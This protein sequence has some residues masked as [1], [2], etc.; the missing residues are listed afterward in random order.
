[1]THEIFAGCSQS[2]SQSQPVTDHQRIQTV[3]PK[4]NQS[5]L[6]PPDQKNRVEASQHAFLS[7]E[8]RRRWARGPLARRC[9]L[10]ERRSRCHQGGCSLGCLGR[11]QHAAAGGGGGRGRGRGRRRWLLLPGL[12][13]DCGLQ[14]REGCHRGCAGGRRPRRGQLRADL[15]AAGVALLGHVRQEGAEWRQRGRRHALR[16]GGGLARQHWARQGA[17]ATGA[18][19]GAVPRPIVQR[20]VGAGWQHGHRGDGRPGPA[21]PQR[22]RR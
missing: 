1:M 11:Q 18:R 7:C 22:A 14:G 17:R 8:S 4:Q 19:Q 20:P 16:A 10:R 12:A 15:R 5:R 6:Q 21:V 3:L 2:C 9:A 13:A